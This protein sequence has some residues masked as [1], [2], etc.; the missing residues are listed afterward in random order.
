M[1]G[2]VTLNREQAKV[3]QPIPWKED[4]RK[5]LVIHGLVIHPRAQGKGHGQRLLE[6][7]EH[8]GKEKGYESIRLDAFSGNERSNRLY[9]RNGYRKRGSVFFPGKPEGNR[10]YYCYEKSL[11]EGSIS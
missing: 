3:W 7:C 4:E 1:L 11:Q 5:A 10:E 2:A 6:L 9:L 8:W